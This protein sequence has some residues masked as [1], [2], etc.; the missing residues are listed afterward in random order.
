MPELSSTR[1]G[2]VAEAEIAAAAIN[3]DLVVL[4]PLC[5]GGRYDLVLDT[6]SRLLRVQCKWASRVGN[7]LSARC[8]TS[9]HT[10]AGYVRST[11]SAEEIDA[12]AVYAPDTDEC[13]LIPA[14]EVEGRKTISLR[15]EPT[16]NNQATGVRWARDYE[17]GK[18][19]ARHWA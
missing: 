15:L 10:P 19:L 8:V 16:G 14:C 12:L 6:G 5:E 7:V 17:L 3:L 1:K 18:A 2:A 13:Y 9:R 11:Y 4:R